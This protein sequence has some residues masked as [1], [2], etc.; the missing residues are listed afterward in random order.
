MLHVLFWFLKYYAC[1]SHILRWFVVKYSW[2]ASR[3]GQGRTGPSHNL[4]NLVC[5]YNI[6]AY[7]LAFTHSFFK[8]NNLET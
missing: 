5:V 1:E 6:D 8:H 2:H 4:Q 7:N 3:F